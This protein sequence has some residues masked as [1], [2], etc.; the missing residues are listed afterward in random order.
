[1]D[2][3]QYQKVEFRRKF[4]KIFGVAITMFDPRDNSV[5]GFV[6][7]KALRLRDNVKIYRDA[8]MQ[9]ELFR[10]QARQIITLGATYDVIDSATN[11]AIM[12]L[13][14]K[15]LRSA[16]WRDQWDILDAQENVTG[17]IQETSG[18]LAIARRWLE[19]IPYIGEYIGLIFSFYPQTYSILLNTNTAD[20]PLVAGTIVH[21]KNPFIVKMGLD[22]SQAQIPFDHR[23]AV[24]ATAMLAIVDAV[25]NN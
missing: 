23:V 2:Y 12:A 20:Q 1:M 13:R 5:I 21:R 19:F 14:R 22:M 4:L 7:L 16:F 25:K 10:V 3:S 8:S 18:A 17:A 15:A 24:A 11:Q 6:K 9:Q